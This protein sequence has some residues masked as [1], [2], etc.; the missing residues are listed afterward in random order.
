MSE[1]PP[2]PPL[3]IEILRIVARRYRVPA[4]AAASLQ[5]RQ[6]SPAT[7]L[8]I[9]IEQARCAVAGGN[10]P[11]AALKHLFTEALARMIHEAMGAERADPAFQ[12]MV[13]RHQAT[14]VREYASLSAHSIQD[15][16]LIHASVNAIAHAAK[17]RR[18]PPGEQRHALAGLH[19]SALSA[20]W[21]ALCGAARRL[22]AMP[23]IAH[24]PALE[25]AL[26]RLLDCPALARLQ[27]M[28]ALA[29]DELVQQYQI[30]WGRHGPRSGSPT[31]IAQG[32]ASQQ[33]GA[34]VEA[35][36]MQAL[37]ALARGLNKTEGAPSYRVVTSMRVPAAI[38]ASAERAKS[39]W[40]AVLLRQAPSA[41]AT[42]VW[43]VCLLV[44]AKAS[45]D[46]ATTDLPRLL[47]GV[48][49]LA[50]AEESVVYPFETR[51]GTVPVRG[52]SLRA[53][54]TDES[55]L[56]RTVLYCCDT[57]AEETPRLLSAASR[58]QLLS[59]PA[60]LRFAA[61]LAEKHAADPHDLGTVWD[62]LLE[63]SRWRA[64]LHQYPMR[65]QVRELMVHIEDLLDAI[66]GAENPA[67][68]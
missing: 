36:A 62:Q 67:A 29:S 13:L 8:A 56:A 43:D 11:D 60:S 34:A 23:G 65:R 10:A 21:S 51:Q 32:S 54:S 48:R 31:A 66:D 47:R 14:Q 5:T 1:L 63:S 12:A 45:P 3:L 20:S 40:D 22:L 38:P 33:R 50:H 28:E 55:A 25:A 44:E 49:L 39:E 7:M 68:G 27:R 24:E 19:A 18:I 58:M 35:V 6:G 59:A 61:S 37:D 4:I 2:P 30:L 52:A 9:A 53:L 15:R 46:A 64:V 41:N 17:R 16:R 26:A 42:F 57:P